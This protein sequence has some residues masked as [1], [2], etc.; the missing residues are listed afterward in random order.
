[1]WL[2]GAFVTGVLI[3]PATMLGQPAHLSLEV[4]GGVNIPAGDAALVAGNNVAVSIGLV[5][6]LNR[7]LSLITEVQGGGFSGGP[8]E[9]R[10]STTDISLLRWGLGVDVSVLSTTS[11]AWELHAR[12]A[13][14]VST[15]V[16]DPINDPSR[17]PRFSAKIND[18]VFVLSG[19]LQL[20]GSLGDLSPFVRVQPDIYFV[21][22]SLGELQALN[23][24][25]D[26]SGV[27]IG[28]PVQLGLK[29]GL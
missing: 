17:P 29:I 3:A 13:G 14:G 15:V 2:A 6:R 9:E 16:T 18:D 10:V 19:G 24:E 8:L 27:I 25:I 4:A 12:V 28:I 7:R 22:S 11:R 20:V 23:D 21:G 26:Q 5:H 1:M